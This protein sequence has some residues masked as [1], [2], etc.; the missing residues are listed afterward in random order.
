MQVLLSF[1]ESCLSI[2]LLLTFDY[3]STCI[4]AIAGDPGYK[5]RLVDCQ[6]RYRSY[7]TG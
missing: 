6:S 7:G 5:P 1:L 4:T 2:D 3:E